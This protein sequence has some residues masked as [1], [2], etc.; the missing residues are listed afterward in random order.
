[1]TFINSVAA[2][3]HASTSAWDGECSKNLGSSFLLV[4]RIG[5]ADEVRSDTATF[6][7]H[8]FIARILVDASLQVSRE[9]SGDGG[10]LSPRGAHFTMH[11]NKHLV[12][13]TQS[14]RLVRL[15]I[16]LFIN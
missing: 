13:K 9:V 7:G 4:W 14:H 11:K 5:N 16:F 15:C 6:V 8:S 10:G 2:I 1:M 12:D 3:V